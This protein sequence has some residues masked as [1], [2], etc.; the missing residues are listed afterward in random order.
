MGAETEFGLLGPLLV[1]HGPRLLPVSAGKQRVVLAALLLGAGRV[2]TVDELAEAVWGDGHGPPASARV[3]IQNHVKRLRQLLGDSRHD[4]I[5]TRPDGYLMT[6]DP[7]EFDKARFEALILD[8]GQAAQ[9]RSWPRA[10][11]LLREAL[12]LW[13]GEPLAD[14][15]SGALVLREAPRLEEMRLQALEA[16]IDA[17]LHLGRHGEVLAEVTR[18]TA[19]QPLRENLHGLMMLALYR[20]GR[21]AD[22]LRAYQAARRQLTTEL[23]VEP[24]PALRQLHQQI[25]TAAPDLQLP[26]IAELVSV[27][28]APV[29]PRQLP[30]VTHHF[31]GRGPELAALSQLVEPAGRAG[32]AAVVA[33]IGG[34][35][36]VGKTT[37]ALHWA[38]REAGRFPDGQLYVNLRGFDPSGHPVAPPEA[39]RS[40]LDGLGVAPERIQPDPDSRAALYRSMLAGRR[41]LVLLDNARDADQVRPLLPGSPGCLVLVTSRTQLTSLSATVGALPVVLG[42]L[43]GPEA[44]DLLGLHL[45]PRVRADPGAADDLAGI[46]A[47]LP[48]AL[49]VT[50]ARAAA[51]P[52]LP[53]AQLAASLRG[54]QDRLGALTAGD[55]ATDIRA[56]FSCSYLDLR[57]AAARIFRLLGL[58]PGPD[59]SAPAAASLA[60]VPPRQ[61]QQVLGEL[62]AAHLLTEHAPGRY[63]LHDL[64]RAYAAEQAEAADAEPARRGARHRVLD[65][66]LHTAHA[67]ALLLNPTRDVIALDPPGPGV[68]PEP[69]PDPAR[70]LAWFQAEHKVLLAMITQA[71]DA[72]FDVHAW[73]LPFELTNFL[74]WQGH[75]PDWAA[76]Q[77]SAL[78]AAQRLGDELGQAHAHHHLGYAYARLGTHAD[79]HQ[80]LS[81]ALSLYQRLGY[82]V[83]QARVHHIR[84]MEHNQ[85]SRHPEALADGLQAL[86]LYQ[87]AG[88]DR[89]RAGALN[90]VGWSHAQLGNYHEA[91]TFSV[92]ALTMHR[93]LGN[94]HGQATTLDTLGYARHHLH[95]Y[96]EAIACYQQALA[97]CAELGDRDAQADTLTHLGDAQHDAG[98]IQAAADS[99]QRAL[100]ILENLRL[101]GADQVRARLADAAARIVVP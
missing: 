72:G 100:R 11:A 61:A 24:G 39:L 9:A 56:V 82:L 43:T 44:R 77:R 98:Q 7:G 3:T 21:Q 79:A 29:T 15:P 12:A 97:L 86:R 10:S 88:H 51:R 64:L 94:Q 96:D 22:A 73:Q 66:Y 87:Q 18:L 83:G 85:R 20:A 81:R 92:Q 76:T 53:L 93:A 30:A 74:D 38:H 25:L 89:G 23:G 95:E 65:H 69:L 55:S 84:C 68:R 99:W 19:E 32:G 47:R 2:L 36:G 70:A 40:L 27:A 28:P 37:L 46:C 26:A 31:V 1:R 71:G 101:P 59:I 16:R 90:A 67:A 8:A 50:A 91:V 52:E 5:A 78:A 33:V 58:H 6:V 35:A 57:P 42:M 17:D 14:V 80:H 75:W 45:G 48:L 60:D 13:R 41:I 34:T 62:T 4:R 49:A 54:T 63:A